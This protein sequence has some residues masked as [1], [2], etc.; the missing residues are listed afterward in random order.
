MASLRFRDG[1]PVCAAG[2]G[3]RRNFYVS[4]RI[5]A[6]VADIGGLFSLHYVGRQPHTAHTILVQNENASYMRLLDPQVEVDGRWYRLPFDRT[7][8][9]PFGY[10]SECEVAGVRLRHELVLDRNALFRRVTVLDNPRGL[11]IRA[12]AVTLSIGWATPPV[13]WIMEPFHAQGDGTLHAELAKSGSAGFQP[14]DVP[15]AEFAKS[16][17]VTL[18]AGAAAPLTLPLNY[19]PVNLRAFPGTEGRQEF[20]FHQEERDASP[21]GEHLFWLVFDRASDED[22]SSA[23]MDRVIAAFDRAR[24]SDARLRTGDPA[25]DALLGSVAP[26]CPALEVDGLGAFRASPT[27]WVWGWDAMVHADFLAPAGRAAEVRRML[28][29]FRRRADPVAGILH[30]FPTDFAYRAADAA[31]IPGGEVG[32]PPGVQLF[33]VVLL[34]RYVAWTGDDSVLAEGLPFARWLVERAKAAVRPGET[35]ARGFGF[36]PDNPFSIGH[37]DETFSLLNNAVYWQ[38]LRAWHDLTGEGAADCVAVADALHATFWDPASLW[39][40]DVAPSTSSLS[41]LTSTLPLYGLFH[42][43]GWADETLPRGTDLAHMAALARERFLR[44]W[45][46]PM[47]PQGSFAHLADG[48]QLGAYYPVT[49]RTYWSLMNAAGRTDALDDFRRIVGAHGRVWTLPEG[50]T[51]D[52]WNA[53]PAAGVGDEPGNKQFFAGKAWLA[54]ALELHLGLDPRPDGLRLHPMSDGTPFAALGLHLRGAR[55]DIR[56]TNGQDARSPKGGR[57][58]RAPA[59]DPGLRTSD[60]GLGTSD[61]GLRTSS[62]FLPPWTTSLDGVPLADPAF[63]PWSSLHPGSR[64]RLDIHITPRSGDS[65]IS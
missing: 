34:A 57:A 50:Q 51:A 37:T 17:E 5:S 11:P 60:F 27:Y 58:V 18:D 47:F 46:L 32:L 49:D 4:G 33:W 59:P 13:G 10:R 31:P 15:H 56:V 24:R 19:R 1:L 28:D 38:G 54:D 55:V 53:D 62:F 35:L 41:P 40:R 36:F 9:W 25:A 65:P 63:L 6:K 14:A 45:T 42:L 20:R 12:R 22:L 29:F 7:V 2:F 21:D 61:L 8:H 16:A 43:G 48:N 39:W 23:R 52:V 26:L 64:H 3:L 44:G 30:A